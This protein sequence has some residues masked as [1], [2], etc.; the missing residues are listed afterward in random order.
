MGGATTEQSE[1]REATYI[2][3]DKAKKYS[4]VI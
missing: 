1:G 4:T 3:K 2:E